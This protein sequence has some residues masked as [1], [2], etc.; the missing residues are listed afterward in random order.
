MPRPDDPVIAAALAGGAMLLVRIRAD[1]DPP[2]FLAGWR[3]VADPV[4][5]ADVLYIPVQA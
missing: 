3:R 4:N 2:G 5:P 1:A